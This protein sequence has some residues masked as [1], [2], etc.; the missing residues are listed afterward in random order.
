M[1]MTAALKFQRAAAWAR[2]VLAIEFVAAVHALETLRP[3]KTG[4]R[5]ESVRAELA[6]LI[7]PA[8]EDRPRSREIEAV[9][10]WLREWRKRKSAWLF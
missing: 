4:A 7:R 3:L 1:G 10:A 9:S 8:L 6:A 2:L 5:L